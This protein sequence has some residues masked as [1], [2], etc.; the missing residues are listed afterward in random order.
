[1]NAP[2]NNKIDQAH[3]QIRKY[4]V[5]NTQKQLAM[6]PKTMHCVRVMRGTAGHMCGAAIRFRVPEH[7]RKLICR[8][9]GSAAVHLGR[10]PTERST[11][12]ADCRCVRLRLIVLCCSKL[13]WNAKPQHIEGRQKHQGQCGRHDKTANDREG[14]R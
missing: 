4:Q 10:R 3:E 9:T 1:M 12:R 7:G 11:L 14:K 13:R 2:L 5:A 8:D 6:N